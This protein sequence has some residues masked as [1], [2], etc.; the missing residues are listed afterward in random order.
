MLMA[1]DFN[2]LFSSAFLDRDGRMTIKQAALSK[3]EV[4]PYRGAEIPDGP[5]LGLQPNKVYHLLRSADALARAAPSFCGVPIHASHQDGDIRKN[6]VGC[7]GTD[8]CFDERS[9][10]LR[11]TIFI[12]SSEIIRKLLNIGDLE[13][14]PLDFRHSLRA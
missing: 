2:S 13:Q 6:V 11:G 4:N 10:E 3:A 9:Q 5:R 7:V 12:W 14:I 1:F 8:V